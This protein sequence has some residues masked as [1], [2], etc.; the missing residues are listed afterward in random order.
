MAEFNKIFPNSYISI[1]Y[2]TMSTLCFIDGLVVPSDKFSLT[3]GRLDIYKQSN[4]SVSLF[5][6]FNSSRIY[7]Y[8]TVLNNSGVIISG[9]DINGSELKNLTADNIMV[10]VNGILLRKD[11]YLVLDPGE[12][13][14][15]YSIPNN[16]FQKVSIYVSDSPLSYKRVIYISDKVN[17][18]YLSQNNTNLS[19]T[20]V[21]K[22]DNNVIDGFNYYIDSSM[23]FVNGRKIEDI[24]LEH[25]DNKVKI[26]KDISDNDIIEY[27]DLGTG[28]ESLNFYST[29]G[30]T[31]F[32]AKDSNQK[33]IPLAYNCTVTFGDIAKYV[34]DNLT[35]GFF[36]KENIEGGGVLIVVDDTFETPTIKCYKEPSTNMFQKTTYYSGEYYLEVPNVKSITEYLSDFDRKYNFVPEIL[37][38]FQQT[39]LKEIYDSVNRIRNIRSISKVD[40]YHINKLIKL[41]GFDT[42][43]KS[44]PLKKRHELLEELD[45]WYRIVG[46]KDSYNIFNILQDDI[47]ILGIDQLFTPAITYSIST[48]T[49]LV[50]YSYKTVD[51][52]NIYGGKNYRKGN[53]LYFYAEEDGQSQIFGFTV[54]DVN[55]NGEITG[56]EYD[57]EEGY[58]FP[59]LESIQ[60]LQNQKLNLSTSITTSKSTYN[61]NY[62]ITTGTGYAVNDIL[63]SDNNEYR[64]KITSVDS[65]GRITPGGF[66][67]I[68]GPTSGNNPL[69]VD[70]LRLNLALTQTLNLEVQ[71]DNEDEW[72]VVLDTN[73]M[74]ISDYSIVK[75]LSL[76]PGI[77]KYEMSGGGGAGATGD[78][79]RDFNSDII[80]N[81]G[82]PGYKTS[83]TFTINNN[84]LAQYWV[85]DGGKGGLA[86]C[87]GAYDYNLEDSIPGRGYESGGNAQ[88][89]VYL[90]S[91]SSF[92]SY[93]GVATS[94]AGGGSSRL[95]ITSGT[96]TIL[97]KITC[98]GAGGGIYTQLVW[99]RHED[100]WY[101]KNGYTDW[102][103][104]VT[105]NLNGGIGGSNGGNA[106]TGSAG[107]TSGYNLRTFRAQDGTKGYVKI[108]RRKTKYTFILSGSATPIHVG[109]MLKTPD[110]AFTIKVTQ[111]D[112][113]GTYI[114]GSEITPSTGSLIYNKT[115]YS[116]DLLRNLTNAYL[117]ISSES[118]VYK[119]TCKPLSGLTEYLKIGDELHA[120]LND[121][122]KQQYPEYASF[123]MDGVV[124][125]KNDYTNNI[126]V[127]WNFPDM[128]VPV[129]N[130]TL[131]NVSIQEGNDNDGN[132]PVRLQVAYEKL[133]NRNEQREYVDF[134][135]IQ[136]LNG[137]LESEYRINKVDYGLVTEITPNSPNIHIPGQPDIDYGSELDNN[138]EPDY[139]FNLGKI[140]DEIE[141]EWVRWW[142][143]DR[144][145]IYYP[146]NHV[147]VEIKIESS[148]DPQMILDR[149]VT[150]FYDLAS[151]V[152]YIH[153]LI[154]SYFF[155][156][157][158]KAVDSGI[159][160]IETSPVFMGIQTAPIVSYQSFSMT[161]DPQRQD[162]DDNIMKDF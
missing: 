110:N 152:L 23:I 22:P 92:S 157:T 19:I 53:R 155:G 6:N 106:G 56:F 107:G 68:N 124:I 55:S 48:Q 37:E 77:Y 145:P 28:T 114:I 143:W 50:K 76:I 158:T 26:N 135:T 142:K 58:Q 115:Y 21:Y 112:P 34:V 125:D 45:N 5:Y 99:P 132:N 111:K 162:T 20:Y 103:G 129:F 108:W 64:F 136:E 47:K 100:K 12:I 66:D 63:Y 2:L 72:E 67:I 41:L 13:S 51:G 98:G 154:A 148:D 79:G 113:T 141:G 61:Y 14:L 149:F 82:L 117:S 159:I 31:T 43:I 78:T 91:D 130:S 54:S 42:D 86:R 109:D 153:N 71:S 127:R 8:N 27:Y 3:S 150:Q 151:T 38:V 128:H 90:H 39:L 94:G 30:F 25:R 134:Y 1:S 123:N 88:K 15:L 40:S 17:Y 87:A 96:D 70:S 131:M 24:Y 101:K 118:A 120:E 93:S 160:S 119:Y 105:V 62:N 46:T 33:K 95:Y 140:T 44:L 52:T 59:S 116:L 10:F 36:I 83:G 35:P 7:E 29:F 121:D 137:K 85:G 57:V 4:D 97:N 75:S 122:F 60:T 65:S 102:G 69:T 16:T 144:N 146:T 9:K 49:D 139:S 32:T 84:S 161:S 74:T 11:Q 126:S 104:R 138:V 156:N 73:N 133:V 147:N 81:N 18:D 89:N 80:S